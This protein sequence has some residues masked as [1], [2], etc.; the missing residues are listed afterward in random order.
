MYLALNTQSQEEV[1]LKLI[2][3]GPDLD[4]QEIAAAERRGALLQRPALHC[5]PANRADP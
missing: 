4:R 5:R 1:A 2:E 3:L